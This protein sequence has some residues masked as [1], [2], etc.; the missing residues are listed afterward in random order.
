MDK[1]VGRPV[2]LYSRHFVESEI[3]EILEEVEAQETVEEA[4]GLSLADMWMDGDAIARAV[5]DDAYFGL[6]SER[7]SDDPS[8]ELMFE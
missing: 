2:E 6:V 3:D 8:Q 5:F 1:Q 4:L 7:I